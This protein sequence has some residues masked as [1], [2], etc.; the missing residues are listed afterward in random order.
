MQQKPV[1]QPDRGTGAA[2]LSS[3]E[4]VLR[5]HQCQRA[6]ADLNWTEYVCAVE[7]SHKT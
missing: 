3:A 1:A 7:G 2:A 6:E 5:W 4:H